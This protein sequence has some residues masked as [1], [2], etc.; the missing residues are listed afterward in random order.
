MHPTPRQ[1]PQAFFYCLHKNSSVMDVLQ[2]DEL[3]SMFSLPLSELSYREFNHLSGIMTEFSLDASSND[4]W[5]WKHGKKAGF[6]AKKYY[7]L[8][9]EPI[10][11]NP[12]LCWVWKSCCSLTIKMFAWLV[13][14]DRVNT[15]DMI[16]AGSGRLM[17][18]L[19]VFFVPRE[20]LKTR[21]ICSSSAT[22]A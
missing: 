8:V 19:N 10:P 15:K 12:L 3:Q 21:T 9:H 18:G 17:M 6:T 13:I 2:T 4:C 22:T 16:Q 1:I 14:M 5:Q 7:D 11:T 20:L